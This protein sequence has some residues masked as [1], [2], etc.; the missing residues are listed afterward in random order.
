MLQPN[1][2]FCVQKP[3]NVHHVLYILIYFCTT[4]AHVAFSMGSYTVICELNL[5]CHYVVLILHAK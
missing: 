2:I 4:S 5:A 3:E 1:I